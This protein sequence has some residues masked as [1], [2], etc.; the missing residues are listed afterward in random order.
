VEAL[1]GLRMRGF[2]QQYVGFP[3]SHPGVLKLRAR[4][5]LGRQR[6]GV[7]VQRQERERMIMLLA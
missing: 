4:T 1:V 7:F 5:E 3:G 2:G 6:R